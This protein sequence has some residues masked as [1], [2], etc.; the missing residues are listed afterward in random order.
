MLQTLASNRMQEME[1][2]KHK[3]M[4]NEMDDPDVRLESAMADINSIHYDFRNKSRAC[5]AEYGR[6]I[7]ND[8]LI[9]G[10]SVL[11]SLSDRVE[12]LRVLLVEA[13]LG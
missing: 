7:N 13:R 12:R 2:W 3:R 5:K 1:Q 8:L 6:I 4:L 11:G 10:A 9:R